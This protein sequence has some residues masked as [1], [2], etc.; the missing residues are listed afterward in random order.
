MK[1]LISVIVPVYNVEKYLNRCV[2]SILNQTYTN[3]EVILVD[4]GS[5]DGC[6]AICDAYAKKD[7]RVKVIHKANGGVSDARNMGIDSSKSEYLTFVDSDDWLEK[8]YIQTLSNY[9]DAADYVCCGLTCWLNNTGNNF[10][11]I[12]SGIKV[13]KKNNTVI[14]KCKKFSGNMEKQTKNYFRAFEKAVVLGPMS[15]IYKKSL[16]TTNFIVGR[17]KGE[18]VL[19][20]VAYLK[21]CKTICNIDYAGY[22]YECRNENSAIHTI[23]LQSKDDDE[24][25]AGIQSLA[26]VFGTKANKYI[27]SFVVIDAFKTMC[28]DN[29]VLAYKDYYAANKQII[30]NSKAILLKNKILLY[31]IKHRHFKLLA[32]LVRRK[33]S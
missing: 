27:N 14:R 11:N 26:D 6:P 33:F 20:N 16:I 1:D 15:K 25:I 7:K 4:D 17:K 2:D 19:F 32:K 22:N 29:I 8:D 3:L 9:V 13:N 12:I 24:F 5:P 30:K 31:L 21:N 28:A 10:D 18:D 23:K